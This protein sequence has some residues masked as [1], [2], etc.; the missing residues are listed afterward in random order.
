MT[1]RHIPL[2]ERIIFA[3]DFESPDMAKAWVE[4]LEGR[5]RFFKVGLQLFLAGH[6]G[7]ID[8]IVGRGHKVM[9]DLKFFDV[10]ETVKLAVRQGRDRRTLVRVEVSLTHTQRLDHRLE[11]AIAAGRAAV[12]T[13]AAG[14]VAGRGLECFGHDVLRCCR[15]HA[16]H[17]AGRL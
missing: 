5:I 9:L 7:V 15:L 4:R 8:W 13:G 1:T 3:L 6:F 17:P 12:A 10:P 2:D 14:S 11:N 16:H